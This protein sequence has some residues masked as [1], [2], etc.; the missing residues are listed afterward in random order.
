MRQV[1]SAV[2][3]GQAQAILAVVERYHP[4]RLDALRTDTLVE[5]RAWRAEIQLRMDDPRSGWGPCS[6]D[7]EYNDDTCPPS[8]IVGEASSLREQAFTALHELGHH[9]QQQSDSGL[10][11]L[12]SEWSWGESKA[13]EEE[14]CDA[15]AARVLL[16]EPHLPDALQKTGPTAADVVALL[17][18]SHASREACCVRASEFFLSS[19]LVVLL[20][21]EGRVVFAARH[22]MMPPQRG[23]D[24]A[25]TP[26]IRAALRSRGS[27]QVDR[28]HL[29]LCDGQ[30]PSEDLY[31]QAAWLDE[32][33]LVAVLGV[34]QVAWRRF[35]PPRSGSS[36]SRF[37][38]GRLCETC[39]EE[40]SVSETCEKCRQ[41]KFPHGQ[42]GCAAAW[43]AAYRWCPLCIQ[44][45]FTAQFPQPGQTAC[46]DCD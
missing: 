35:S 17:S 3:P 1:F 5:L 42:C 22:G 15:F 29:V 24:Q 26:L 16:P 37:H 39:G 23:S 43:P 7:G 33:Y 4:G 44:R 34:D 13:L 38:S 8:L 25:A 46:R 10:R 9:L 14:A 6:V 40:V 32:N 27:A 19:G 45:K 41:P 12:L 28:T 31:G 11:A 30:H 18:S 36:T 20:D 2:A 21:A